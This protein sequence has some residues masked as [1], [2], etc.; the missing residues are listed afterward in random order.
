MKTRL[1]GRMNTRLLTRAGILVSVSALNLTFSPAVWSQTSPTPANPAGSSE[2]TKAADSSTAEQNDAMTG[3]STNQPATLERTNSKD[4]SNPLDKNPSTVSTDSEDKTATKNPND[5]TL[6]A[7]TVDKNAPSTA[8]SSA[9]ADKTF[10]IKAAQGGITEMQLG[11]LAQ[12]KGTSADVK[13]FGSRM[14][15]DHSRNNDELKTLAQQKGVAVPSQLDAGH[16]ATVDRFKHLSGAA[17]DRAFVHAMVKDHQSDAA[18]F[19]KESASAKDPDVKAF[20]GK[21][22]GMIN[23]HLTE[24]QS[25]EAKLK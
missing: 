2:N 1:I 15:K 24:V 7:T 21:T 13:Q 3:S 25:I 12:E 17:F 9:A 4:A 11:R 16:Q 5:T 19:K 23:G 22:L 6:E 10:L 18:E 20:A 14:V 8:K